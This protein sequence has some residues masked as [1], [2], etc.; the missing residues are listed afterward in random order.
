MRH[1]LASLRA[2]PEFAA[3]LAAQGRGTVIARHSCAHR[4]DELVAICRSLGREL[5]PIEM[6]AAQ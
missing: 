3:A 2:D 5:M 1:H 4:V 6:A